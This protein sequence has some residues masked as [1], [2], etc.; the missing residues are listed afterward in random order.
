MSKLDQ[1]LK[2]W[3]YVPEHAAGGELQ[4][5]NILSPQNVVLILIT[6]GTIGRVYSRSRD[7]SLFSSTKDKI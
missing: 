3:F 5:N 1:V 6:A 2:M 7:S 4:K